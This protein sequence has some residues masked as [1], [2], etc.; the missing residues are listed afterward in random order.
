MRVNSPSSSLRVRI[1]CC[2]LS[3][4]V[5]TSVV[6]P[7]GWVRVA[8]A[9][10][11]A[12]NALPGPAAAPLQNGNAAAARREG[13]LIVRF[14]D[15]VA[16][17]LKGAAVTSR[18]AR[19]KAKARGE[20]RLE[21]IEV[22]QGQDPT[23][24]V[25]ALR[26][27][28]SVELVEPN[29]IITRAQAT[30]D[31]ARF[32]EQWALQSTGQSGGQ[33]GSDVGAVAAWS[34]TTGSPSTVVAVIDSGIDFTHPDLRLN[35]WTNTR[36]KD[37][38]R[39]KDDDRNGYTDDLNGWDWV[40]GSGIVRDA[41]GHGTAIAGVIAAQGGNQV[42]IAGVMWRAGLMSL[43]VL[44]A[45][46]TGD[47]ASAV[48]AI[49]YAAA[50]GAR[51]IN[52]SWGT[53]GES[54]A[55]RDAIH[56]AGQRGVLVVTSAGNGGRDIDGTPYYPSSFDLPNLIAVA[57]SDQFDNLAPFSNWGATRVAVAAPGVD[58]LTTKMGGGYW[59]VSG[60]S[61]SA[62]LVAG[63]AGLVNTA[64]PGA[65]AADVRRAIVEGA[66]RV[67]TLEGKVSAAGV[68][69]AA[70][71]LRVASQGGG[72]GPGSGN[73]GGNGNGN[74]GDG[75]GGPMPPPP[76]AGHGGS[77]DGFKKERPASPS[78]LG[79][80]LSSADKVRNTKSHVPT[81][82]PAPIRSNL[83]PICSD[84]FEAGGADPEFSV[85]RAEPRNETGQPNVDL[86]SQNFNWSLPLVSLPGRAGLDLNLT[87]YYNSLTWTRQGNS[88][89]YNADDGF[90]GPGFRLGVPIIQKRF[91]DSALG[92]YAYMM[93]TASGGR[94]KLVQIGGSNV[95]ES[96]DGSYTQMIDY[97]GSGALVRTT[98]GTQLSLFNLA[99][100]EKRCSQ[101]KD[102]NGNYISI[103]YGGARLN[104]VIDTLGRA[105][106]FNY[107]GDGNLASLSQSRGASGHTDLLV[108]F[109][110][111]S[112]LLQPTFSNEL[113]VLA[114]ASS[115]VSVL[116]QVVF[117]DDSRYVFSY[118]NWGQVFKIAHDAPDGHTLSW[119]G[120]NLPGSPWV[121]SSTHSDCPRFTER[122]DWVQFG[123]NNADAEVVTTYAVAGD[124]SWSRVTAPD[125]TAYQETFATSGWQKGLTIRTD[126]F[127]AGDL[128]NP[129]KWTTTTWTQ[130]DTGLAYQK[131]S[132]VAET[133]VYDGTN[134]RRTTFEYAQ[135]Y[136][137]PTHVREWAGAAGD[138][139]LRLTATSYNLEAAYTDRRIIG[140]PFER[141]V[142]DGPSGSMM[143]RV[144]YHYD[145]GHPYSYAQSPSTQYDSTNYPSGFIHG[146]GNLVA[147]R[148]YDANAPYDEYKAVWAQLNGYDM[149]GSTV[150]TQDGW[151]HQTNINYAD[152]FSDGNDSRNTRAY[153]TQ[154]ADPDN[155][156]QTT[157]YNYATGAVE[158]ASRPS[159]GT[160]GGTT[161]ET[162]N[163]VYDWLARLQK[164]ENLNNGSYTRY[165]YPASLG[166]QVSFS[167]AVAGSGE[168][169]SDE[170][171]DGVG[172]V[173]ATRG[174]F[175][176]SQGGY[177]AV[178]HLYDQMG[179]RRA[180]TN[181][182][183][184]NG[185]WVPSG[186]D[187][188]TP[189]WVFTDQHY[190]WQG[191]P[192]LRINPDQ[193][194]TEL[195]YGGCG[196]AGGEVVTAR[197]ERGRRRK[198][199]KDALGRL[200]KVEE[201][202]FDQTVYS[203]ATYTY[204]S[205]DQLTQI[206]HAGQFRS[207]AYDGHGRLKSR[208]TP[209]QGTTTYDYNLDDTVR[210][211]TDARGTSQTFTYNARHLVT[212]VEYGA[213][214]GVAATANVSFGYDAAGNRTWMDDGPGRVDYSY[215]S[216]SRM[217]GESRTFDGVGTF[218]LTYGYDLS[219][220]ASVTN[221]W[222]S[223]VSY[224]TDRTG[225][226]TAVTGSG[227]LS[228]ATYAQ[229]MQ[230][231]ASGGLKAAAYG[232]SRQLSVSYDLRMRPVRWD[233]AGV[234]GSEYRYDYFNERTGRVTFARNL[235]DSTLDRSYE[236]DQVGRLTWA[237]TGAEARAHAYTGQWGTK[238]GP[239]A[240]AYFYDQHGNITQR[241]GDGG[242]NASYSMS[243]TNNRRNDMT[244]DASGN[245][246]SDGSQL[247]YD[248]TGQR[249]SAYFAGNWD[250]K[251][252]YDGD[253]QRVRKEEGGG[254]TYYVRSSALGGQVVAEVK[255]QGGTWGWWRG[256]VY[257][258]G[259][260]QLLAVQQDGAV[261]WSHE[262]P[263]TKTKRTTN[264]SGA[265]V[266]SSVIDPWGGEVTGAW[267]F[268]TSQQRRK[269]T[270][271]ER[272]ANWRDDA[273]MRSY[274]AWFS[275]FD[276]PDPSDSSYDLTNPQSFNRFSYVQNDPVNF[277]DPSGLN[278][279]GS[280][281]SFTCSW[282]EWTTTNDRGEMV[283]NA[284]QTCQLTGGGGIST[285]GLFFNNLQ[286]PL[287]LLPETLEEKHRWRELSN[288]SITDAGTALLRDKNCRDF[289]GLTRSSVT[290]LT[291]RLLKNADTGQLAPNTVAITRGEGMSA[292]VFFGL[293]FFTN[294]EYSHSLRAYGYGPDN[295]RQWRALTVL[296]EA[297]HVLGLRSI[298]KD[299]GNPSQNRKNDEKVFNKCKQGISS[300]PTTDAGH[301]PPPR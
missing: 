231:R 131:N 144:V 132:R 80:K 153:P 22:G 65:G 249:V 277:I 240:H 72:I 85:A 225:A 212:L 148:R 173:R 56:R 203:T 21:K 157:Q 127:A 57:S 292:R 176:G 216:L 237:F 235:Y 158:L 14:R 4:T 175:P 208:T 89:Q 160:G 142:F 30:P 135:G 250:V 145:W 140:L 97:G 284:S 259:G 298:L 286:D 283:V 36:E 245:V 260:G 67:V 51:V 189:N 6:A 29:F 205:R 190:D 258:G 75:R 198:L 118:T 35:Q 40:T 91:Y 16:E 7:L 213:P 221:P 288:Q 159:S 234:M 281:A 291:T 255:Q 42:G 83:A 295:A 125:G 188:S 269:F 113:S 197:D 193:T 182:T 129:K 279:V 78:G 210:S 15:G 280:G 45:T 211:V 122:R 274:H 161:Y 209:E 77:K 90:P 271:Y 169:M 53:E 248:A 47:V 206:E 243:F 276:Q 202:N 244:Y 183:E 278:L 117:P 31:D 93:V 270:T 54:Q 200:S 187:Q 171:Y 95:Y 163:Y 18:G 254:V 137:L 69:S 219:G 184:V 199:Y 162:R 261:F 273:S 120:Y 191:R 59:T 218:N 265:V 115:Y 226:Q 229:G 8:S 185:S 236:Y 76:A 247:L 66:R 223:Q 143:S 101:I 136:G 207:F 195:S 151:G 196:C 111:G 2:F 186:D 73:G 27:D 230:Y 130:D 232:N 1:S 224:T 147:V 108:A 79:A 251:S 167:T 138:Q 52:C 133:S 192:T 300:L 181:P 9:R 165:E 194:S 220:L 180:T 88:I 282:R 156:T 123:V 38:G 107:D 267:S 256:Y 257:G 84:C 149:A 105:L 60:T 68:V 92:T 74:Q 294:T 5:I 178:H 297:A 11:G 33:P 252:G 116:T 141:V 179:R 228:V 58:V 266:S 204:N 13:E 61:A 168:V 152:S 290:D 124:G 246:T 17:E 114:P 170:H 63:I 172:R 154:V 201:L 287:P 71:A 155:A 64:H 215:D 128:T 37:K 285:A 264:A 222:G 94:V 46:G 233:V 301:I 262:D 299:G 100:G 238:D 19:R 3:Y 102:A 150:W 242:W 34:V 24:V 87:L 126:T 119:T 289:F 41:Q 272:D 275:R 98:D 62:P 86:G 48:E 296:H 26:A 263:V 10:S 103:N 166:Y 49:D 55:L 109:G 253:R 96:F 227:P 20:S 146:R 25:E 293:S 104:S 50:M 164:I 268:N 241:L 81:S 174:E 139:F 134:R 70:G 99:N 110:Y 28:P 106:Y 239:Y 177:R 32:A 217:T 121:S 214:Y 44:D 23:S 43:R 82:L 112:L 12:E 39:A